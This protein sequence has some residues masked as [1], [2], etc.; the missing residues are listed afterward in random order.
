M[1]LSFTVSFS[2][3]K[4]KCI[5]HNQYMARLKASQAVEPLATLGGQ[6]VYVGSEKG[7]SK[8]RR[9]TH[10]EAINIETSPQETPRGKSL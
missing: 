1:I 9:K 2:K 7:M 4:L 8:N 5:E 6:K 3:G 10:S